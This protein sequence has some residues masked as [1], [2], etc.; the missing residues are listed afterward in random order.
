MPNQSVPDLTSPE[1]KVSDCLKQANAPL[2]SFEILPPLKGQ[3][4]DAIFKTID[5]LLPFNPA[6]INVTY[7]REEVIYRQVSNGFLEKRTVRKRPG[8]VAIAA[9]I[10]NKYRLNVVPHI[11]CGGFTREETENALIDLHFL[12][13]N[14]ILLVR[15]DPERGSN[16]FKPEREGHA[17]TLGL[18]NQVAA[19]K[20]GLYLDEELQNNEALDFCIGV[21]GYPEKHEEAPNFRID[22]EFLKQKVAA[23]AEY[24][25]TQMFFDNEKYFSFVGQCRSAGIE[26]PIIPGLKPL[27]AASQLQIIP[28]TFHVEIPYDL[29][30][31]IRSCSDS[32]SVREA[33]EAWAVEQARGLLRFGVPALHFFTMGKAR[34]VRRIVEAVF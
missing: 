29:V 32:Q 5:E 8:T 34:A 10:K 25:V 7:H 6:F 16:V 15:G 9:A 19:L 17:N 28:Q 13:I 14:N 21:A 11:I 27:T 2:F 4:I 31:E 33:G 12:G 26:V 22:I 24:I 3:T 20:R 23:G 18:V 1:T 30:K